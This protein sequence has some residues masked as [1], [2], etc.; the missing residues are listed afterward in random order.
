MNHLETSGIKIIMSG[1]LV[2]QLRER[3]NRK[4]KILEEEF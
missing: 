3:E 2:C 4:S 1:P